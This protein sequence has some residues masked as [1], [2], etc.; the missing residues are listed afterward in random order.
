MPHQARKAPIP[1]HLRWMLALYALLGLGSAL[2]S[3]LWDGPSLWSPRPPLLEALF[4]LPGFAQHGLAAFAGAVLGLLLV[5]ASRQA[6]RR[7]LWAS[8]LEEAF[9]QILGPM[10]WRV[11]L[12][13][14]IASALAEEVLFRGILQP[15]VGLPLT[16]LAFGL[17]HIGPN[18]RYLPWTAMALGMG[19]VLGGLLILTGSLWAPI[20]CHGVINACN[21]RRISLISL[22]TA[23]RPIL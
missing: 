18:R 12:M 20:C 5:E 15:I 1:Q 10:H 14:A 16:A 11:I 4:D 7:L 23:Q 8:K 6:S 2:W 21:L 13:L 19:F 3:L 22:K 17:L 9:A